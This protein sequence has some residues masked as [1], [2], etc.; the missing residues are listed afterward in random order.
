MGFEALS[1]G[2]GLKKGVVCSFAHVRSRVSLNLKSLNPTLV[3]GHSGCKAL[4]F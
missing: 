4:S 1:R 2:L 3:L